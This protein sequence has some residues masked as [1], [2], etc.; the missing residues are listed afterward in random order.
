MPRLLCRLLIVS[1]S[2]VVVSIQLPCS[3]S[4]LGQ[5]QEEGRGLC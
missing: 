1:S 4:V 2:E 3:S 5:L